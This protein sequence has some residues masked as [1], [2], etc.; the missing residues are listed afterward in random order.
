[1][2][3]HANLNIQKIHTH[4]PNICIILF[5]MK[6]NDTM[7]IHHITAQNNNRYIHTIDYNKKSVEMPQLRP[8]QGRNATE[9]RRTPTT[10]ANKTHSTVRETVAPAAP[11]Q[12][13]AARLPRQQKNARK[14]T[15]Q[16]IQAQIP[17]RQIAPEKTKMGAQQNRL[18]RKT[19]IIHSNNTMPTKNQLIPYISQNRLNTKKHKI[20]QLHQQPEKRCKIEHANKMHAPKATYTSKQP[21]YQQNIHQAN[22]TAHHKLKNS[23]AFPSDSPVKQEAGKLGLMWPRGTIANSHPAANMLHDYS[24]KGCPV[25][26]GDNWTKQMILTAL[27]RGPHVSAKDT[28]AMKYL[29]QETAEKLKGGYITTKTWGEIK[30]SYPPNMKL[31]PLAMIPHK[32]RS[33]RCILDL[34]FQLKVK[35][36]KINSVNQGT[37]KL[38]PQKSMA[39]LGWVIRRIVTTMANNYNTKHP[40]LFSK[41]DIKDGFWRLSVNHHDAWNF[42][43]V[44]PPKNPGTSIDELEIVIPH[45]LQMGWAESPPF[46]CAATETARDIIQQYYTTFTHIPQ[47]PL[48]SYLYNQQQ[49]AKQPPATHATKIEVYVDDFITCTNN[50]TPTHLKHL[51]RAILVGIHSI[52]PP[53]KVSG[54]TGEDPVSKTKLQK[55][56]GLF[57]PQKE[58]LGWH[59]DGQNFTIQLPQDKVI[60]IQADI[61]AIIHKKVVQSKI[62]EKLQG[63]LIHASFGIPGG[64]GLMSPLYATHF[65]T[66]DHTTMTSNIKQC[67]KDWKQLIQVVNT[68]P[69]SVLELVPQ[70]P[71]YIGYVDS[72]KSAVGGVWTN[73]IKA[74]STQWVWRLEWPKSIQDLLISPTNPKGTLSINDLEMAGILLGW[75][76]LEHIIPESI[77]G[78]HIGLFCDNMS[79]VTWTN[80]H[81]TST[82]TIAGHLL[83]ALALRQHVNRTSPLSSAHIKGV[84]NKMADI[85]SR[86]FI[87]H[88][89]THTHKSFLHTFSSLFPLQN[90][91]W[92]EYHVPQKLASRVISCL[93]GK[94][95]AMASWVKITRPEKNIGS[96][97]QN[98]PPN[99]EKMHTLTPALH[100]SKSS[101][102][103][104]LLHGSG[105]AIMAKDVLSELK[106]CHKRSQP[107]P[108]PLNWLANAPRSTKQKKL[109]KHQ[110]HGKWKDTEEKIHHQ[111]PN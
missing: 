48:E 67:L 83:R 16:K 7:N 68:R 60:K 98:T 54:H 41:C 97:G 95:L 63:K 4:T 70:D 82:S 105:A 107:Y 14:L 1:M 52:F 28:K 42:C 17:P 61:S 21:K 29:Y 72:S 37:N 100:K 89:F 40:F 74:L 99:S 90:D 111:H 75:L 106:Q 57:E 23:T 12:N 101:S 62:L 8:Q 27:K 38:S 34:S 9:T 88:R 86:S 87:D 6:D 81:S 64:R 59:I 103:Q 36:K 43:Y 22:T 85:A 13:T 5:H 94:P 66:A 18:A 39:Q 91:S 110:W 55:N 20:Q 76:I 96:T 51:S 77:A 33:Y 102:S 35:G 50:R 108:R 31:S 45:A 71:H 46:F 25:D 11:A 93:H 58:V 109:T 53:P 15:P 104:H 56:E 3:I 47:H 30:H 84:E 10:R 65:H 19:K 44:L 69:T 2:H 80:K 78:S 49:T 92:Q 32:S 24:N 79:T 26:A 73:G